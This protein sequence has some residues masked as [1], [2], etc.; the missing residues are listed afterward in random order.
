MDIN[1]IAQ[2]VDTSALL[3]RPL[4]DWRQI[5]ASECDVYVFG[6]NYIGKRFDQIHYKFCEK[7]EAKE[8]LVDNLYAMLRYKYFPDQ[9]EDVDERIARIVSSFTSNLKTTLKKVSLDKTTDAELVQFIPNYCIAFRNGVYNFK[10]GEWL[11]K[12]DIIRVE[13]ISNTLYSYDKKY[14]ILWYLDFNFEPMPISLKDDS[15]EDV[16]EIMKEITKMPKTR[17]FCFELLYNM[18]HDIYDRF[19]ITRFQHACEVLGY[20]LLQEF[21][22]NFVLLIGSGQNGKNSLFDGCFT[23]FVIPRTASND[24]D[25]LENDRFITGSLEN[26]YQNIYLETTA[27]TYSDSKGI[28]NITGSMYQTIESKGVNKYSG[29]I[30][31]KFVFA[32]NDQEKIKFD[33][34]TTGFKRRINIWEIYY[35]WDSDKRFLKS[36]DYYDTTFNDSLSELK[37]DIGNAIMFVYFGI[38]GIMLATK[39]F[40]DNF[41]FTYNDWKLQYANIDTETKEAI[42]NVDAQMIVS[43]INKNEDNYKA[44]KELFYDLNRVKLFKSHSMKTLGYNSYD[45]MIEMLRHDDQIITFFIENDV[46]INLKLLQKI[47]GDILKTPTTFTQSLKKLYDLNDIPRMGTNQAYVKCTFIGTKLKILK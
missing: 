41:K 15:L 26:K 38:Y 1:K 7:N 43:Y 39:N 2:K 32:G 28:K 35:H 17:N 24:L 40:T 14:L 6:E 9:S 12:Y 34:T 29:I 22:Q 5:L 13:N 47:S 19:D 30:N 45:D 27:K 4:S 16:V 33:D 21:S 18:S 36:G 8:I 10:D 46:Y 44:C 25:A 3:S 11:F 20:L 23:P 31:C 42:E 37:N